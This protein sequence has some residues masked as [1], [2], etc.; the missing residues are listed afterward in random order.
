MS[1]DEVWFLGLVIF[2]LCAF[3]G[4]LAVVST[5]ERSWAKKHGK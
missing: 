1:M 4:C 3:A 2:A 5:M